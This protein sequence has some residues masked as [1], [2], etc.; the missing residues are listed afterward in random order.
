MNA[1]SAQREEALRLLQKVVGDA[2][3]FRPG[4]WEAI[5]ALVNRCARLLVV[6]RT[7]WGKSVVYFLTTRILRDKAAGP[8]LLVSPLLA[9][10][11][12]QIAAAT[13]L[14]I[15]AVSIN[16]TNPNEWQAIEGQLRKNETWTCSGRH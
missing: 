4:Q 1:M 2:A 6:Q 12:N 13:A 16:S 14:G 10:M 11:R 9:L 15:K 8:T 5:E 7:G 3:D